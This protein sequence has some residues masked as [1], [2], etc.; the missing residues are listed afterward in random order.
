[1][2]LKWAASSAGRRL[3]ALDSRAWPAGLQCCRFNQGQGRC[4]E[5]LNGSEGCSNLAPLR[6][7]GGRL[8][9][10]ARERGWAVPF[11]PPCQQTQWSKH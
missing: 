10:G 2:A 3:V 8:G 11:Q 4:L 9:M 1:M 7:G 5:R 6:T